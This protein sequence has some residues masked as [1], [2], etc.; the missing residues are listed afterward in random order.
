MMLHSGA[1]QYDHLSPL[2]Y[3]LFFFNEDD[4]DEED[5]DYEDYGGSDDA[6]SL[7]CHCCSYAWHGDPDEPCPN[8]NCAGH[9][10]GEPATGF[11]EE[12][13]ESDD[14]EDDD[15]DHTGSRD[16]PIELD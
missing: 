16:N 13:G 12:D 4:S 14:E 15:V 8:C 10:D 9:D 6:T 3:H 7:V 1:G 5:E 2:L 11:W